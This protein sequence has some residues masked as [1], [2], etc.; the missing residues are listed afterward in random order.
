M[1]SEMC[2]RDRPDNYDITFSMGVAKFDVNSGNSLRDVINCADAMMYKAKTT[3][4]NKLISS[5]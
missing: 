5:T 2:I 3:G 4:R 1:G